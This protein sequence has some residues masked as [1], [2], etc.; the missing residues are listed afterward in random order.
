MKSSS[1]RIWMII[2]AS[3]FFAAAPLLAA[4]TGNVSDVAAS[5][6]VTTVGSTQPAGGGLPGPDEGDQAGNKENQQQDNK[7]DENKNK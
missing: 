1:L 6:T 4:V 3:S 7:Q 5:A 2:A